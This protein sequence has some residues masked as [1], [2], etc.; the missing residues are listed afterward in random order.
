VNMFSKLRQLYDDPHATSFLLCMVIFGVSLGLYSGV[1]NN[2][3]HE[4]LGISR[5]ERGI[6]EF[7]RELPGLL[8][9]IIIAFLSRFSELKVMRF[10]FIVSL[11]GMIGMA[12]LGD[13]RITAIVAIV[14]FST[15]EHMM[16][17]IQKSIAMHMA[18]PGNEGLAMGGV[19]SLANM[20]QVV[21]HY[22]IPAVFLLL[23]FIAPTLTAFQKFRVIF[24][25][26]AL[27]VLIAII[28][29]S[30]IN[31]TNKHIE[32]KKLYF[33]KKYLKYY[34]L[35][36]FFGS[37]KQ[38]FLTFAP[39]VL[40][41]KYGAKT[42]YIAFLYGL[43]SFSTIF[44]SPLM[45]KLIDKVGYKIVIIVDAFVLML[46]CL[47]YGFSHHFFEPSTA[48]IIVSI[49]FVLDAVL[50]LV[51]MARALYVRSISKPEEVTVVLSSGISINHLV[52]I[53]I[54]MLGGLLWERLGVEILFSLA[55]FFGLG[56]LIFSFFL[57]SPKSA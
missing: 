26:G 55:A 31:E 35:E 32:R 39:Y 57:P 12:T 51:G 27:V 37:R 23:A 53:I 6:V 14:L 1:L 38:V 46:L 42:E 17:P 24:F 49:V 10:A 21:G 41:L 50:F 44:L 34:I 52:S 28:F 56:S 19:T 11:V 7:P 4:V 22:L 20:G 9:F 36:M 8:L 5:L 18:K 2:Y 3:L 13:A 45:G 15:G 16:M 33:R 30:R 47:L 29:V 40:I 25:I 48:F 43:W 54:A